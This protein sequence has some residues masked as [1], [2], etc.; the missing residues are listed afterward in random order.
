MG[1]KPLTEEAKKKIGIGNSQ[2]LKGKKHQARQSGKLGSGLE[3]NAVKCLETGT[4]F[5]NIKEAE[6]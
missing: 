4:I 5:K 6:L 3:P 2:A 1:G